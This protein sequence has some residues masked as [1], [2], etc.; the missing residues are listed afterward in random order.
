MNVRFVLFAIL[1]YAVGSLTASPV[2]AQNQNEEVL[3]QIVAVVEDEAILRSEVDALVANIAQQ[4]SQQPTEQLWQ[5]ALNELI[6]QKTLAIT[7]RR[8]TTMQITDDQVDQQLD[9]RIQQ[10]VQRVGSESRLEEMYGRSILQIKSELREDFREQLLAQQL[11]QT[12]L[13][14]VDITPSEVRTWF[15]RIPADSLPELPEIVRV[16]HIVRYPQTSATAREAARSRIASIRD[17]IISNEATF[18]EMAR[19][20]SDHSGSASRGGR[21]EGFGLADLLPEFS[22]VA[23]NLSEGEV[24]QVFETPLGFHVMRL[25]DRRGDVLDFN[26]V[27]IEIGRTASDSEEAMEY[28]SAVRDSI[29]NQGAPF[30]LM[31][32]RHSEEETSKSRGGMVVDPRS[33]Q[34]DLYL[35]QLGPSWRQTIRD[36]DEGEISEPS[37]VELLNGDEAFHIVQLQRHDPAHRISLETDYD[38]IRQLALQEKQSRVMN[39][40]V[41]RLRSDLYV[42]VRVPPGEIASRL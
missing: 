34:R 25:N 35:E 31:A 20:H 21:M 33:G 7:A 37:R 1:L 42:D 38:R 3:D 10:M 16:S 41:G 11:Q 8:D 24:S 19:R 30:A 29:V 28:L 27:L 15:E 2:A 6:N 5:E 23:S 14:D 17:S 32:R 26:H 9:Q 36:L 13:R 22:A 4:Q 18:E 40:W 39:E 12:K